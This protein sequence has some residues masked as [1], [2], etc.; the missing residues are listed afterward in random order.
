M[1]EELLFS[2]SFV[3][4]LGSI[5]LTYIH[6]THCPLIICL[7]LNISLS[8]FI[9]ADNYLV[10]IQPY[11]FTSSKPKKDFTYES[12]SRKPKPRTAVSPPVP[13]TRTEASH[14]KTEVVTPSQSQKEISPMCYDIDVVKGSQYTV[15]NYSS[16]V[17]F[18][19]DIVSN[20]LWSSHL[21]CAHA[22][23]MCI[24]V[25]TAAF[26]WL[27]VHTGLVFIFMTNCFFRQGQ[28]KLQLHSKMSTYKQAK[29]SSFECVVST[30]AVMDL[31]QI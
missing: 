15:T 20:G 19:G 18:P 13:S 7:L 10:Q 16:K 31:S 27:I 30:P 6:H 29:P 11:N 5:S 26:L 23:F 22:V 14:T 25:N 12:K 2:S 24:T 4:I 9:T 1:I 21:K 17:D 8:H 3:G 28:D